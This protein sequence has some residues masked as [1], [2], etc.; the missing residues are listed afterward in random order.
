MKY[1]FFEPTFHGLKVMPWP[2][3]SG[4]K[5]IWTGCFKW[6]N[7][8]SCSLRGCKNTTGKCWR[9][10]EKLLSGPI[11]HWHTHTR[12]NWQIF[13]NLQ[14]WPL[15]F[16]QS[17]DLQEHTMPHWKIWFITVWSKKPKGMTFDVCNVGS[18][19]IH[20]QIGVSFLLRVQIQYFSFFNTMID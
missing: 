10:K 9:S 15:V 3:A 11:W 19:Y 18:K 13:F 4:S 1:G 2:C 20:R 8:H 6:G 16:L 5:Q 12:L 14:L 17:L 7:L